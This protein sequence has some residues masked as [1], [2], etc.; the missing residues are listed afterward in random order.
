MHENP[1]ALRSKAK[2]ADALG[3]LLKEKRFDA[4]TITELCARAKLSRPA[5]YQNFDS[6]RDVAT[7][8]LQ[9]SLHAEVEKI[10]PTRYDDARTYYQLCRGI[11]DGAGDAISILLDNGL[12]DIVME[13]CTEAFLAIVHRPNYHH[14]F[15]G[16]GLAVAFVRDGDRLDEYELL[17]VLGRLIC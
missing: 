4:I 2:L 11:Y 5:F 15:A 1:I 17:D 3:E 16:A 13:Q 12:T 10:Y 7:R 14:F 6:I 8:Y 9:T